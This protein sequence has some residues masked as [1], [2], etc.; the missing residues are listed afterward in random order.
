MLS[1]TENGMMDG[2]GN[3]NKCSVLYICLIWIS[4]A[5]KT[6]IEQHGFVEFACRSCMCP[7]QEQNSSSCKIKIKELRFELRNCRSFGNLLHLN[8]SHPETPT[9][10]CCPADTNKTGWSPALTSSWLGPSNKPNFRGGYDSVH[11]AGCP[12]TQSL[13]LRVLALLFCSCW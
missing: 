5:R 10:C 8:H 6:S 7:Q 9:C 1:S 11:R 13:T 2:H 4:P 3:E 12:G